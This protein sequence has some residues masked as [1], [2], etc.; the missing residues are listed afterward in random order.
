MT[1]AIAA[2]R[3]LERRAKRLVSVASSPAGEPNPE[4]VRLI[5]AAFEEVADQRV[6]QLVLVVAAGG[7]T[8]VPLAHVGE[9]LPLVPPPT[10]RCPESRT[11]DTL[12]KH[13]RHWY[14]PGC[15]GVFVKGDF[16]P[17]ENG[18]WKPLR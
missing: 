6:V 7:I 11:S 5:E 4:M 12:P 2:S 17:W 18:F 1:K 16:F 8:R 10:L 15:A 13:T 3:L 9:P 14:N